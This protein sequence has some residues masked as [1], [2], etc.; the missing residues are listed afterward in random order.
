MKSTSKILAFIIAFSAS[1]VATSPSFAQQN[2]RVETSLLGLFPLGNPSYQKFD[3]D[4]LVKGKIFDSAFIQNVYNVD[5]DGGSAT[6]ETDKQYDFFEADIANNCSSA[7]DQ[8]RF[9][10]LG[11]GKV[12][13]RSRYL[14]PQDKPIHISVPI[15]Q[16]RAVTLVTQAYFLGGLPTAVWADPKLVRIGGAP[17]QPIILPQ[18]APS[19]SLPSP[20]ASPDAV[21][22]TPKSDGAYQVAVNGK[23]VRFGYVQPM[24]QNGTLLVPMRPLFE[25]LGA[26]VTFSDDKQVILATRSGHEIK[27]QLGS[28]TASINGQL[29]TLD[30]PAQSLLGTT[31]V[32]LRFIAEAFGAKISFS[33]TDEAPDSD[34]SYPYPQ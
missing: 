34:N 7:S 26:T 17:L 32:P 14:I 21:T 22:L 8:L 31:L 4:Y 2:N 11:D 29:K 5:D 3:G 1:V 19:I 9:Y 18:P 6:Y 10:V 15:K 25:A 30:I 33:E 13:Y 12:L 24:I 27:M 23:L 20:L 16:Y 28:T